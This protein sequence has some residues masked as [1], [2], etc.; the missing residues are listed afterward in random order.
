MREKTLGNQDAAVVLTLVGT[1]ANH[2]TDVV[3]H[4][5]ETLVAVLA[6]LRDDNEIWGGLQ[7]ALDCD[8]RWTLAHEADEVP[9][10]DGRGTVREHVSNKLRV[11]LGGTVESDRRLEV[12]VVNISVDGSRDNKTPPQYLLDRKGQVVLVK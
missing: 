10:F 2:V 8:M 6:L 9:V 7:G 11:D 3:D 4:V 1:L 12:L 5:L